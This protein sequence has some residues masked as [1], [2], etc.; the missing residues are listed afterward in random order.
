MSAIAV[1][2]ARFLR[3]DADDTFEGGRTFDFVQT[4]GISLLLLAIRY[5]T[6][7]IFV[8]APLAK[9]KKPSPQRKRQEA[10]Y[11]N[12][13]IAFFSALLEVHAV[14]N[15]V[16]WNGGCTPWSTDACMVAWPNHRL[17]IVQRCIVSNAAVIQISF[18][19]SPHVPS[20]RLYFL[21][22]FQ[23]Y[24]YEMI[25][26]VIG[27]GTVLKTEMVIH[28][29]ATMALISLSYRLNLLRY[30]TMWMALFDLR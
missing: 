8:G 6:E 17:V 5:V 20:P 26:T 4:A 7:R 3:L 29:V 23:Y 30:G 25:G 10:I 27:V 19:S 21:F 14:A 16:F 11:D 13:F 2:V 22:M 1:S 18:D 9:G 24:L 28:H 12:L 15:T